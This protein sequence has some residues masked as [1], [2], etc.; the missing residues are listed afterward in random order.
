MIVETRGITW[1]Y[2]LFS[3]LSGLTFYTAALVPFYTDWG[4]ISLSQVQFLQAWLMFWA[5]V[6]EIPTGVIADKFGR[7]H[8]VALGSL[9]TFLALIVYGAVPNFWA[10]LLA[11]LFLAA[12]LALVSGANEALLYESLR[13][14]KNEKEFKKRFGRSFSIGQFAAII[15]AP[16]GGII[17]SKYGL[18]IPMYVTA[19]PTLIA[20]IVI[21]SAKEPILKHKGS[22][23]K[24]YLDIAKKE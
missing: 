6:L 22:E 9:M 17:A 23:S 2:Y 16:L 1:R 10:F 8:S 20:I 13:E 19:F 12:G 24:K 14:E 5:F 7:K 4:H 18:N 11:E 21:M 15:S 3:F